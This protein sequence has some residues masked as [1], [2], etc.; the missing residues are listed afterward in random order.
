[1]NRRIIL[2]SLLL[3][4]TICVYAQSPIGRNGKQINFG[5]GLYDSSLPVYFGMD[6]GIHPDITAGFQAGLDLGLDYISLSGRGDYHFNT[7]LNI[8]R[9]W[10]FYAG[11]SAGFAAG[12]DRG[13]NSGIALGLQIGGRY[14]WNSSWGVNLEIGGGVAFSGG[15]LG[16]SKRF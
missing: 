9:D 15:R 7:L 2:A 5:F 1:M 10:D 8:P 14:Y 12:I 13:Y 4:S 3:F 11:L 16:V 6:F